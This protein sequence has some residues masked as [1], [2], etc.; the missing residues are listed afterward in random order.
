MEKLLARD[1]E[2][3]QVC[4][5]LAFGSLLASELHV[6]ASSHPAGLIL[7]KILYWQSYA[8]I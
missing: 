4:I 1:V 2:Q 8:I 7:L 6:A 3:E 5:F